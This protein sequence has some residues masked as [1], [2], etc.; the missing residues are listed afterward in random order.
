MQ[1]R[2]ES[3]GFLQG[4]LIF[5]FYE[6]FFSLFK[7]LFFLLRYTSVNIESF[8][9]KAIFDD[10]HQFYEVEITQNNILKRSA[11]DKVVFLSRA[12]SL[13]CQICFSQI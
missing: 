10:V 7:I 9:S 3:V 5:L 12:V 1:N 4:I 6:M 13:T 8:Y 2:A 11:E